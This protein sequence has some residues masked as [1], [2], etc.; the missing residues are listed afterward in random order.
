MQAVNL[1]EES[2]HCTQPSSVSAS[3]RL[4]CSSLLR[5]LYWN[6]VHRVNG[7]ACV[8]GVVNDVRSFDFAKLVLRNCLLGTNCIF[9]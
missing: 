9:C 1:A 3:I 7:I 6:I 8:R 4:C 2:Y 5:H